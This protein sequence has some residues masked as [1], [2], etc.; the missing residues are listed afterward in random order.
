MSVLAD[1]T[2]YGILNPAHS[3]STGRTGSTMAAVLAAQWQ[4]NWPDFVFKVGEGEREGSRGP[5]RGRSRSGPVQ[6]GVVRVGAGG[7]VRVGPGPGGGAEGWGPEGWE[8][9]NVAL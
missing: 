7:A 6:V 2:T 9:Q 5:G 3:C 8:A 4:H 1:P